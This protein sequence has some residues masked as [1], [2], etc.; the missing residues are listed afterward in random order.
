MTVAVL[1]AWHLTHA[2][3]TKPLIA[4]TTIVLPATTGLVFGL[5]SHVRARLGPIEFHLVHAHIDLAS[6]RAP[7]AHDERP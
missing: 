3:G 6:T 7:I 2:G 1:E 4:R 5:I